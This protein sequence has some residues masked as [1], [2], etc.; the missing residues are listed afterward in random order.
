MDAG[1]HTIITIS[2]RRRV[3][4]LFLLKARQTPAVQ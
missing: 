4:H 1:V 2:S 3:T